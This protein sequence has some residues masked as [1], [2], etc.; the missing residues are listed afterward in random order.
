MARIV[1]STFGSLGDLHPLI[2]V[3]LELR[4]RGHEPVFATASFY[5]E[6]LE[7]LGFELRPLRPEVSPDDHELLALLMDA[8]KGS[9]RVLR[10]V[11]FPAL[12]DTYA[13]LEKVT[14]DADFLAAAELVYPAPIL[15]ETTG[16]PWATCTLS[17]LSFFSAY[18]PPVP[19]QFPALEKLHGIPL[20]DRGVI[21]LGRRVTRSWGRPVYELRRELG[22][23][24]AG[25]PIFEGKF[26]PYLVLALFSRLMGEPQPDWP[27]HTVLAG[28]AF[29]DGGGGEGAGLSPELE[30]FLAAGEPPLVFT[31][32]S[33]AVYDAGSFYQESAAAAR[34]L[35]QRAVLVLGHNPPPPNL[36]PEIL[37]VDY[38]PFSELFPR[39]AAIVHQGGVGTC[40]Q[41]L[42][43]GR[44]TL[45]MP[46]SHDQPD[47]AARLRRLGTSRTVRRG[48]YT[49]ARATQELRALLEDPGYARRAE[50]A[51]E[52]V[53]AEGGVK[54]ACDAIERSLSTT[55]RPATPAD[56][57]GATP[58]RSRAA[59]PPGSG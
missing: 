29:Y 33:A 20:F 51:G 42:R 24:P 12:R 19:P 39:A 11:M 35:G 59:A 50:E 36:P 27:S 38:A 48:R 8:K 54:A 37:A 40:G 25:D 57:P 47:N 14:R 55:S 5:R 1:L 18:D 32:G 45:V 43:S 6:K 26:S 28:F 30:D 49:A 56:S 17:P 16:I 4:R 15:G 52:T 3:G 2:A 41:G 44:P 34:Q 22:L 23:P 53:R 21:R 13:D 10:Q 7:E 9:E 58:V 46:F 31:L